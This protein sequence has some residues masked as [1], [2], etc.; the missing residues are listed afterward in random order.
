MVATS[1]KRVMC[2]TCN[3][4]HN[5]R[6]PKSDAV[7]SSPKKKVA[8]K[9]ART[10]RSQANLRD[11]WKSQVDSGA[12]FVQYSISAFFEPGQLVRHKKFGDG[13][14]T[15]IGENKVTV[16]FID[17]EKTLAMGVSS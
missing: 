16:A 8:K 1:P 17:G 6:P 9:A 5:Y 11:E 2:M 4:E 7:I 12:P 15:A 3:S 13:Y 14:V 10:S